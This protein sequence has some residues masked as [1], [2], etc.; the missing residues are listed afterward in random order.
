V[1]AGGSR[2]KLISSKLVRPEEMN[3]HGNSA[4][5]SFTY[6]VNAWSTNTSSWTPLQLIVDTN[7]DSIVGGALCASSAVNWAIH[8]VISSDQ[9]CS[10]PN[11]SSFACRSWLFFLYIFIFWIWSNVWFYIDDGDEFESQEQVQV[12]VCGWL[13]HAESWREEEAQGFLEAEVLFL[14]PT[15]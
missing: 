9:E 12:S 4:S 7:F 3:P 13:V 2:F 6:L 1:L 15:I 5:E 10:E 14:V 8:I 11:R